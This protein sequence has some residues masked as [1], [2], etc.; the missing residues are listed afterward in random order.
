MESEINLN[1]NHYS[2]KIG[3]INHFEG[4][5]VAVQIHYSNKVAD[6]TYLGK[7]L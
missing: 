4:G 3:K 2:M 1:L 7:I 5:C 6:T